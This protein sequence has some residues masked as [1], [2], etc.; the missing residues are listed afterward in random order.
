MAK[1]SDS[2]ISMEK[3]F[4][5]GSGQ[6]SQCSLKGAKKDKEKSEGPCLLRQSS[7]ESTRYMV[8]L[9]ARGGIIATILY[10]LLQP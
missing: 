7:I 2:S 3:R 5:K 10:F 4:K 6:I 1:R 9:A 8:A